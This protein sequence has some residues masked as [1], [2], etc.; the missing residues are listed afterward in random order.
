M[1][2]RSLFH[3][4]LVTDGWTLDQRHACF[5]ALNHA[6]TL[7]GARDYQRSL[8]MIRTEMLEHLTPAQHEA[9]A[10]LLAVTADAAL[11]KST[12]PQVLVHDWKAEELLPLLDRVGSKRS[13]EA[14]RQAFAG[15][16]CALC[17][18]MGNAGGLVGP[19][20][21]AVGSR[22]NRRDIL[23]SIL[24]PSRVIDDKFRNTVLTLKSGANVIGTIERETEET[25]TILTSPLL[26]QTTVIQQTDVK[27]RELSPISPMPPGLLNVL[28]KEQ[29]LDLLAYLESGGDPKHRDFSPQ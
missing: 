13:F 29:I 22:F 17:H 7:E 25:V 27:S 20:L 10:P 18:R 15:A 9:V 12:G 26:P 11:P 2:F 21:T 28:T 14:G 8:K 16:Q 4:R 23:D 3:L 6:E 24:N 5:A 19:D 1:L